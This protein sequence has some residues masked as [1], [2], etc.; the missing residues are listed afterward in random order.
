M[1]APRSK[2][3]FAWEPSPFIVVG[4]LLLVTSIVRPDAPPWVLWPFVAVLVAAVVWLVVSLMRGRGTNPDQWGDLATLEGLELVDALRVERGVRAVAPV[5]DVHRHQPAIELALLHG[6]TEQPAVL[7]PRA[8]RWLS[9]RYRVGVQL[10]GDS[11]PRHAGFLEEAAEGPWRDALDAM[12]QRDRYVRV[13]ALIV[14]TARPYKVELDLSGLEHALG[15][16]PR[17]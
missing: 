10:V 4:V 9:R 16:K 3:L 13:P 8:R 7:V 12:R 1:P 11:H 15:E 2:S 17:R 14:G 5:A 6:G